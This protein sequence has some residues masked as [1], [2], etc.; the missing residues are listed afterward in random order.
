M[1][2][3]EPYRASQRKLFHGRAMVVIRSSRTAGAVPLT[4]AAP[5]L[6]PAML[7]LRVAP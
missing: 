7:N 1:T 3:E 4:A 5:G 6:K 2:S